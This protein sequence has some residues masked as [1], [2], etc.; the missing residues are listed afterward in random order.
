MQQ[1]VAHEVGHTLGL[2]HNFKGS[3]LPPSSSIMD[4]TSDAASI[5]ERRRT[6]GG[7][8]IA[9]IQYLYGLSAE[10]PT[11]PFCNDQDADVVDPDCRRRDQGAR[12]LSDFFLPA[13]SG[14]AAA[15]SRRGQQLAAGARQPDPAH[16]A[17]GDTGRAAGGLPGDVRPAARAAAAVAMRTPASSRG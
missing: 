16:P 12:P 9:A 2:R 5:G 13:V 15:V 3:L 4:Y 11:Q 7:Y 17:G 14:V 1:V 8:D 6:A 10:L